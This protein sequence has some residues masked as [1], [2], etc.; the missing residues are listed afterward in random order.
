MVDAFP[1]F[2]GTAEVSGWG[3]LIQLQKQ[4]YT[5]LPMLV[6]VQK[7]QASSPCGW[8]P[9][10]LSPSCMMSESLLQNASQHELEVG[11]RESLVHG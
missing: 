10:I 9:S 11:K 2:S 4:P 5:P 6:R 1:L 3:G 8:V 7:K